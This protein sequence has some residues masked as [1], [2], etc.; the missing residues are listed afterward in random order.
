MKALPRAV[1]LRRFAVCVGVALLLGAGVAPFAEVAAATP[2]PPTAPRATPTPTLGGTATATPRMVPTPSLTP[3]PPLPTATTPNIG[4]AAPGTQATAAAPIVPA[5]NSMVI[6][7]GT[8]RDAPGTPTT[9]MAGLVPQSGVVAFAPP[10]S[11]LIPAAP[12]PGPGLMTACVPL[13]PTG[14]FAVAGFQAQWQAGEAVAANFWGPAGTTGLPEQYREAS[15]GM[16]TVQY[17]DKGRMELAA[18]GTV[19]NGLLA[20]ELVSGQMQMGDGS[21]QNRG[22]ARIPM[23]GDPDNAGP[24]YAALGSTAAVLLGATPAQM[25]TAVTTVVAADGTVTTGATAAG[26]GPTAISAYDET[27]GHNVPQA[28]AE[29][30][31]RTG[32]AAIGLAKAEPFLAVVK[33]GGMQRQVMVQVFERRVLTYTADNAEAFRVEMGNI[34]QHYYRWRYC[35]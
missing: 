12:T 6:D 31:A 16:R 19:T 34:G 7:P 20:S 26:A 30:R 35:A 28:F 11:P 24:T 18:A 27:T 1:S 33:V 5:S 3:P 22:A 29:Y 2:V 17:F 4:F 25:G 15:G 32:L 13:A 14:T 21:F 9:A 23:A 10:V 8:T